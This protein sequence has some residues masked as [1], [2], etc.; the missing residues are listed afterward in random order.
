MVRK[1]GAFVPFDIASKERNLLSEYV[2]YVMGPGASVFPAV[3]EKRK[4]I[5]A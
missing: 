4:K 2:Y 1:R 5:R 3:K